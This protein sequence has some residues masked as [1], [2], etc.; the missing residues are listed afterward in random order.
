[1]ALAE[2]V[3]AARLQPRRTAT[4]VDH[5]TYVFCGDG[6]LMEG[7]SHEACSLAGTLKLG[8]LIAFYDDNG[9]S[10]DGEVPA[11]SPTTRRSASRPMA[12]TCVPRRRRPRR[13]KR[14][15]PRSRRRGR[16]TDRPS[17]ICCKTI[18]GFGAPNKQGTE[19]THGA[20]LGAD[21]VAAA[22]KTL[23]WEYPPFEI[24]DDITRAWDARE[25]RRAARDEWQTRVRATTRARIP[26]SRRGIRAPHE[27]RS[28][29]GLGRASPT[30][31]SRKRRPQRRPHG[32]AQGVADGARRVRSEA[33]GVD[34][35][36]G[37]SH[38][39]EQHELSRLSTTLT[40]DEPGGNYI[41]YGV[42]EFG[43]T[44]I[45]NG[46][47]LHGGFI[48]YG[49][50][51]LVFSDYARNARAHVRADRLAHDLCAHARLDRPRRGRAD[52]SADRARPR[53]CG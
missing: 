52:A 5:Y 20:A 34:R 25:R 44:A 19:A 39:L 32:D 41:H 51:F 7:I 10:I 1:M 12:G 21:E 38:R 53:A 17:L 31:R 42:R 15:R 49:G 23:G 45:M 4:I 37:R 6:C 9:I 11:G 47:A 16:S 22:R 8:K 27:R 2:K 43:M 33:A 18:I 36:L 29:G 24:P 14:S 48:P 35:R 3:L 30:T 50:T 26:R 28:A 13:A 40:A 46:I